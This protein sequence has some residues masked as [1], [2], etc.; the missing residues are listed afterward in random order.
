M[1]KYPAPITITTWA[2]GFSS[3]LLLAV[4]V[5]FEQDPARWKISEGIQLTTVVYAVFLPQC[6]TVCFLVSLVTA[7]DLFTFLT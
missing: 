2:Y 1:K 3:V 5:C 6:W 4:A 7:S